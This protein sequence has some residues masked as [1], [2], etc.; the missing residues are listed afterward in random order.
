M[1]EFF[2][3]LLEF[4]KELVGL[5]ENVESITGNVES[6]TGD[7]E[8]ITDNVES[9][10]G[11]IDS[12]AE[13]GATISASNASA[14]G[15][16]VFLVMIGL[17]IAN[18]VMDVIV[19]LFRSVGMFKLSKKA[20]RKD[21]WLAFIPIAWHYVLCDISDK[22][23]TLFGKN[24]G[25]KRVTAF[26]IWLVL[27][28]FG[29]WVVDLLGIILGV[30]LTT[31]PYVGTVIGGILMAVVPFIPNLFCAIFRGKFLYDASEVFRPAYRSNKTISALCIIVEE[32]LSSDFITLLFIWNMLRYTPV[33]KEDEPEKVL[34]ETEAL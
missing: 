22:P 20:G 9:I 28:Y 3:K 18:I 4:L 6:V 25:K 12:I 1:E 11:F 27:K 30:V 34:L 13:S 26:W 5:S 2:E 31:I 8:S 7:V 14:I 23:F 10:F 17:Y 24:V 32:L 33:V 29:G 21:G 19:Y 15:S 16:I